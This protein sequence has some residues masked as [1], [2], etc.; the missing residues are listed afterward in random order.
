MV[1]TMLKTTTQRLVSI[2]ALRAIVMVLMI[3]VNDLWSLIGIPGWLEHAP[4]DAN[5]LGFADIIFP[6]FLLIVGL[7]V[8]YAIESRRKKGDN[9]YQIFLHI[10]FRS[11][12]LLVM[13]YF[14]VNLEIY[15]ST[16]ILSRPVWQILIT[17]AFFLIWLD[18]SDY[19]PA[20]SKTLRT[21]GVVILVAMGFLFKSEG[22]TG[23]MAMQVQWWGILGLIGW[24]YLISSCVFLISGGK[25]LFQI[26]GLIFFIAFNSANSMG[27]LHSISYIRDYVW[28]V[29]NGAMP[30]L[31][32]AGIITA[33][34]YRKYGSKQPAFWF[35]IGVFAIVLIL[36]GWLTNP[37]WGISKI[38]ATASWTTICAGITIFTFGLMVF[39]TEILQQ[40][41]WY[42]WIKPAGTSTLTCYLLPYIHYALIGLLSIPHLPAVLRTGNV[43]L[44][45]SFIYALLIVTVA[46]L[47]GKR[48][49]R[50]K[51]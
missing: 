42:E 9:D 26:A 46:G 24:A 17:I 25:L 3:F 14:H 27:W 31:T 22:S 39:I 28:I 13:G 10:A 7:S 38:R 8:P 45:K 23:F 30:T 50:L 32:M 20:V 49:I 34:F 47:L 35:S 2:D 40:K 51:I 43:G 36:F 18:Y 16:A 4:G 48:N 11:I 33:L 19:K 37:L 5:Y 41:K 15:D 6:A 1:T 12:A 44:L 21:V 29:E